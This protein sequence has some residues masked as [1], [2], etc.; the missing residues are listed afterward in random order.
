M[1]IGAKGY[2]T[3]NVA[4]LNNFILDT[5]ESGFS[6]FQE[7]VQNAND[8]GASKLVLSLLPNGIAEANHPMLKNNPLLVV[9]NDGPFSKENEIAISKLGEGSKSRDNDSIGK[10]GL[11]MKSLCHICDLMFYCTTDGQFGSIINPFISAK[12]DSD[13]IHEDWNYT[14]T[15]SFDED[16]ELLRGE[17]AK[18]GFSKTS[19]CLFLPLRQNDGNEHIRQT[20]F[21]RNKSLS[22]LFSSDLNQDK[23]DV[24][25]FN[26]QLSVLFATLAV[27]SKK[28][29]LKTIELKSFA[30]DITCNLSNKNVVITDKGE[31]Y[32]TEFDSL[33][34]SEMNLNKSEI[35]QYSEAIRGSSSWPRTQLDSE[36]VQ[37]QDKMLFSDCSIIFLKQKNDS[38]NINTLTLMWASYLPL[39]KDNQIVRV[40][41]DSEFSYT[42][43][44]NGAFA[45]DSGRN[46]I[47]KYRALFEQLF[48]ANLEE[49]NTEI[50][51]I[52]S[53]EEIKGLWNRLLFQKILAP[54]LPEFLMIAKERYP[55]I[56]DSDFD[57]ILKAFSSKK[58]LA[59]FL[60]CVTSKKCINYVCQEGKFTW[61][62][63][64][65]KNY[66]LV[67]KPADKLLSDHT[68]STMLDELLSNSELDA[69]YR[70]KECNVLY[71]DKAI[72]VADITNEW[73]EKSYLGIEVVDSRFVP[74][75]EFDSYI[76]W[77][78]D[79]IV[80]SDLS[81]GDSSQYFDVIKQA[82]SYRYDLKGGFTKNATVLSFV[83]N[84]VDRLLQSGYKC[85]VLN[86][87]LEPEVIRKS[88]NIKNVNI[89]LLPKGYVSSKLP[90]DMDME[91]YRIHGYRR[92]VEE[93]GEKYAG[94]LFKACYLDFSQLNPQIVDV[95]NALPSD[96]AIIP[97]LE[98][99]FKNAENPLNKKDFISRDQ[100]ERGKVFAAVDFSVLE[101]NKLL[102]E[103]AP[104]L[105]VCYT[106]NQNDARIFGIGTLH[107]MELTA[108][109][110]DLLPCYSG[111]RNVDKAEKLLLELIKNSHFVTD[112]IKCC[113]IFPTTEITC[114]SLNDYTV[115]DL[116][117]FFDDN[118]IPE[119]HYSIV[120][121]KN[122]ELI[123][124]IKRDNSFAQYILSEQNILQRYLKMFENINGVVISKIFTQK[125][126]YI[127]SESINI[128]RK[129]AWYELNGKKYTCSQM[130]VVE[131]DNE[132]FQYLER[133]KHCLIFSKDYI[134]KNQYLN[135]LY[136]NGVLVTK[137]KDL[138]YQIQKDIVSHWVNSLGLNCLPG[139]EP[140]Q[141]NFDPKGKE[142]DKFI[143]PLSVL[144]DSI[145]RLNIDGIK[146][147]ALFMKEAIRQYTKTNDKVIEYNRIIR[148][149]R[150]AATTYKYVPKYNEE[151]I[152]KVF[153]NLPDRE[154]DAY[155]V[156]I[157]MLINNSIALNPS[158]FSEVLFPNEN[159]GFK[160]LRYL[161][162][163]KDYGNADPDHL[164]HHV[165]PLKL[166]RPVELETSSIDSHKT[167]TVELLDELWPNVDV[168]L[169]AMLLFISMQEQYRR[170]AFV[171]VNQHVNNDY[172][173]KYLDAYRPTDSDSSIGRL[174]CDLDEAFKLEGVQ[175]NIVVLM[176]NDS[177]FIDARSI[178]GEPIRIML[179]KDLLD[180]RAYTNIRLKNNGNLG[181]K[182]L[183]VNIRPLKEFDGSKANILV[184]DLLDTVLNFLFERQDHGVHLIDY[185]SG[186]IKI[187]NS[188]QANIDATRENI[189][190]HI[191]NLMDV[192]KI[193][194][195]GVGAELTQRL[196][197]IRD[198]DVEI[199]DKETSGL[200]DKESAKI[201]KLK[202]SQDEI[203]RDIV[204]MIT[205]RTDVSKYLLDKVRAYLSEVQY[206]HN[207]IPF[208]LFQNADDAVIQRGLDR[209]F[210]PF[211]ELDNIGDKLVFK[212]N[213]R[214]INEYDGIHNEWRRDLIN[215]LCFI[216]SKNRDHEN[217][218]TGKFGYGFK[219]SYF[220]TDE[221]HI[222]S[223]KNI[224][225]RIAGGM[226]PEY[227]TPKSGSAPHST[228]IELPL[229]IEG[230][231]YVKEVLDYFKSQ[232]D[233]LLLFSLAIKNIKFNSENYS[234][235][236]DNIAKDLYIEQIGSDSYCV[237]KCDLGSIAFKC[238]KGGI[239][240]CSSSMARFW[241]TTPLRIA[242]GS[243]Y[244]LNSLFFKIDM[245]RQQIAFGNSEMIIQ[246]LASLLSVFVI[247]LTNGTK[248]LKWFECEG[249][250]I[251]ED[252][253]KII[254]ES[255]SEGVQ[256]LL[257][258]EVKANLYKE[259]Y[260]F[261]G[262][263]IISNFDIRNIV[264]LGSNFEEKRKRNA[265][266]KFVAKVM[267]SD[268]SLINASRYLP[269]NIKE[270]SS[271]HPITT[272]YD[273]FTLFGTEM[274][275]CLSCEFMAALDELNDEI[276]DN[277]LAKMSFDQ[278][279]FFNSLKQY[280][281]FKYLVPYSCAYYEI[282]PA[283]D[284][285]LKCYTT[286]LLKKDMN[287]DQI[288]SIIE[289]VPKE[290]RPK[291]LKIALD[292]WN[293]LHALQEKNIPWISNGNYKHYLDG[294]S[295]SEISNLNKVFDEHKELEQYPY[296]F[297]F[298]TSVE[299]YSLDDVK[300]WWTSLA[301]TKQ[302]EY[303]AK[304]RK[305]EFG[306]STLSLKRG[307]N[308]WYRLLFL[309]ILKSKGRTTPAQSKRFVN[310][311]IN[312]FE[313]YKDSPVD[314]SQE[315][316]EKMIFDD[317]HDG[318][319]YEDW[320][321]FLP[322]FGQVVLASDHLYD[323]FTT[324]KDA[325]NI[326]N[327]YDVLN[328]RQTSFANG[329]D[330]EI[331]N[332]KA[333]LGHNYPLILREL[334]YSPAVHLS[335][336]CREDLIKE[337]FFITRKISEQCCLNR[338]PLQLYRECKK[339]GFENDYPIH[340][341]QIKDK[342][343][344]EKYDDL[345]NEQI[346]DYDDYI[347]WNE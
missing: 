134:K 156:Y 108:L 30:D 165:I 162:D 301:K 217:K 311:F 118:V 61:S 230:K 131:N 96:Y 57:A 338:D 39:K 100:L 204:K 247:N 272:V 218:E 38:S 13:T 274:A 93:L 28:N 37:T 84:T 25:S 315:W 136:N 191:D 328:Y 224:S 103:F 116:N 259:G 258:E 208:E 310:S 322:F 34:Y 106:V 195:D 347:E 299:T 6:I 78:T 194:T 212:H 113:E 294:L 3:N 32:Q 263:K 245:G 267:K 166:F 147:F 27:T 110:K 197:K 193:G 341:Y 17:C 228:I 170:D 268:H 244:L 249:S 343:E 89:L 112:W 114:T 126:V 92:L 41:I 149:T 287:L 88:W 242:S 72:N 256:E 16:F 243:R 139:I 80:S 340:L 334:L 98:I 55:R 199:S 115:I 236:E 121:L 176:Q 219:S 291:A 101:N 70:F 279:K 107:K 251:A 44:F 317:M 42:I 270:K 296:Q 75:F 254:S 175:K 332:L 320:R 158:L 142:Y 157:D 255:P 262:D 231:K 46:G 163:F 290:L 125:N 174:S 141:L 201:E 312:N 12:D 280:K 19:F 168:G 209:T 160:E 10:F 275:N 323:A 47:I 54:S 240:P 11:G 281:S 222:Y 62:L 97:A 277:S 303:I 74:L 133:E 260:L 143:Q 329:A 286:S 21:S 71:P 327:Y 283:D 94:L 342:L 167:M 53:E 182:V 122:Y 234:V 172:F 22:E 82:L 248:H 24:S 297:D 335:E 246:E 318:I 14:S 135:V 239:L 120:H 9:I 257:F 124:I 4:I 237:L 153:N 316:I 339:R 48:P 196:E 200:K 83:T 210:E 137:L 104:D 123:N 102:F 151:Y 250:K 346:L 117:N 109:A 8:A 313:H 159:G 331:P 232:I 91:D 289:N 29:S 264:I 345:L 81:K 148:M 66:V 186:L 266:A 181:N 90:A 278:Y 171:M 40:N 18:F 192:I 189:K 178:T 152:V 73:V 213:G 325:L 306:S 43:V 261:T 298:D 337:S 183:T 319:Q 190:N 52:D 269:N 207:N 111:R 150:P 227:I 203:K 285:L 164:L 173:T 225:V 211:F 282:V 169:K 130:L 95:Y 330:L 188:N 305:A 63:C 36:G 138:D 127:S 206:D 198:N 229:N 273:L 68:F 276:C 76:Q 128:L 145:V 154:F 302:E 252:I 309:A 288:I 220:I 344:N 79:L 67:A 300:A 326:N 233:G 119:K 144:I 184:I 284:Q 5:Y 293:V 177:N 51:S 56:S 295:S 65:P 314:R 69:V 216:S 179:N 221:P 205:D 235:K 223:G 1:G 60:K 85:A 132:L 86:T 304:Y 307:N 241:S 59:P 271:L 7:L 87:E 31:T 2:E 202:N 155:L 129:N 336:E 64:E 321:K 215:M 214:D 333:C 26:S 99:S 146:Y 20:Y 49:L 58:D 238:D 226:I 253:M 180:E 324:S 77:L 50:S 185:K 187:L 45:I 35:E 15:Q 105:E 140:N 23:K 265:I 308:D 33:K 161:C 292:D